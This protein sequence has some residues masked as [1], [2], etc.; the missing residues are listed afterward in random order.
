MDRAAE[1]SQRFVAFLDILGF[2]DHLKTLKS[3]DPLFQMMTASDS[4]RELS[5]VE[6]EWLGD[7]VI[8]CSRDDHPASFIQISYVANALRYF[9]LARGFLIR[10]GVVFT[11]DFHNE[12]VWISPALAEA[13]ELESST[14]IYPRIV[15]S[16]S[17]AERVLPAVASSPESGRKGIARPPRFHVISRP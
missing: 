14:A 12:K 5:N 11:A 2:R 10:G 1:Y 4:Y 6:M 3:P 8:L 13:Y 7:A 15:C 9:F 17:V 16:T